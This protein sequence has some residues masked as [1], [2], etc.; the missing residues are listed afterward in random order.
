MIWKA[1]LAAFLVAALSSTVSADVLKVNGFTN[2]N[3][4]TS[5]VTVNKVDIQ[6]DRST[7]VVTFDVSG[8]SSKVQDVTGTLIVMMGTQQLY[9]K[10]FDPCDSSTL[11]PQL[12]PG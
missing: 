6:F 2:C 3:N 11:V 5:S 12:C 4:G 8:S 7:N 10:S 1:S 9:T